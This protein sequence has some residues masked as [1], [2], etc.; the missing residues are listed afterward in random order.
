[1]DIVSK[2]TSAAFCVDFQD[3]SD[4]RLSH[5]HSLKQN[6]TKQNKT[7]QTE[8]VIPRMQMLH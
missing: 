3:D 7:L 2:T 8:Q 5:I 6:K 4:S 1:L